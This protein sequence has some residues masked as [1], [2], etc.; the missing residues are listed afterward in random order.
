[1]A[2]WKMEE[3]SGSK[4]KIDPATA[5]NAVKISFEGLPGNTSQLGKKRITA[6]ACGKS[7][8]V[9]VQLFFPPDALN[10]PGAGSGTIPNWFFYWKQTKAGKGYK[11]AYTPVKIATDGSKAIGQYDYA[12]DKV[13]L[14]DRIMQKSCAPRVK[15]LGG[16]ESKGIDCFAETARHETRHQK[17]RWEWW[18]A[19]NP[20]ALSFFERHKLDF[21]GDL[22]PDE[23]EKKLDGKNCSKWDPTSCDGRPKDSL[24][25]IEM[26]AYWIGWEWPV[27]YADSEDW[28]WCGKQ[29]DDM[30]VCPGNKRW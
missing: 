6:S 25:D 29:W 9:V 7:D 12:A 19:T 26:N 20:Q 21:D 14:T 30:A 13:F 4:Q 18:G 2:S 17:E 23:V 22:V 5:S 27:G 8:S 15:A 10:H 1:D 3:L 24:F 16:K 28:S 11:P